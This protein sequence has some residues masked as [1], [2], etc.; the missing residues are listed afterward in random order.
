MKMKRLALVLNC[1][2]VM[3]LLLS[4][5]DPQTGRR[6]TNYP[7]TRW[8]SQDPDMYFVVGG[9]RN[10]DHRGT[11]HADVTYAQIVIDGEIVEIACR[12]ATSG[13]QIA[14]YEPS[15]FDPETGVQLAGIK[16]M[17]IILFIGLCK[18]RPDF[19]EVTITHNDKGFLDDSITEIVFIREDLDE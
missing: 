11:P 9:L 10:T 18:F 14:F 12:F 15:G 13:S 2:I 5:C 17:D 16:T 1:V 3:M 7:N 19:I 8:V 4:S 6:P